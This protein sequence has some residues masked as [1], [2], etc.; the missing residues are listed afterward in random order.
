MA[1]GCSHLDIG[2]GQGAQLLAHLGHKFGLRAVAQ[3]EGSLYLRHVDTEGV[4]IEFGTTRLAPHGLYL[5][6][7]EQELLGTTAYLVRLLQRDTGQR[8]HVDGERAFVE[9]RQER[10]SQ[11][12]EGHQCHHEERYRSTQ[13]HL[14]M[15][16]CPRQEAGIDLGEEA[17]DRRSLFLTG[18]SGIIS[19]QEATQHRC[20]GECHEGRRTQCHDEGY[21]ERCQHATLHTRKEEQGHEG[22]HDD[23]RRVEDGHAHL[24]G[25]IVDD[26]E[27]G[28]L[29]VD[30][31]GAVL[32]QALVDVLHI[33]DGIVH[34]RPDGDG[35]SAEAHRIDGEPQ[36]V[37]REDGGHEGQGDGDERDDGRAHVHQEDEEHDDH[38]DGPLDER[39]LHVVDGAVDESLLTIHVGGEHH[40]GG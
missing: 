40:V 25:G 37:E 39:A 21:A 18:L 5:G 36:C 16:E 15:V 22:G 1:D 7:G 38:E 26:R 14:A 31:Q 17:G 6:D 35:Q 10:T 11:A 13:H 3:D 24:L 28:A 27:H 9:R 4:L 12:E 33:D 19:Q 29:L 32:A 23:E 2:A 8:S 30:G 34:E 20:Q